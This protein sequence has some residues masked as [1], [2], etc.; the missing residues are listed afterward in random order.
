MIP[1]ILSQYSVV[2]ILLEM[3]I[4]KL[5]LC[6]IYKLNSITRTC[7]YKTHLNYLQLAVGSDIPSGGLGTSSVNSAGPLNP[8]VSLGHGKSD[9]RQL[10]ARPVSQPN[11]AKARAEQPEDLQPSIPIPIHRDS[12]RS[13]RKSE[14]R[15]GCWLVTKARKQ[16]ATSVQ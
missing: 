9:W 11:K 13:S 12:M 15:T 4:I 2:T 10:Q 1:A 5:Y 16:K 8:N 3:I 14:D 7:S 6:L